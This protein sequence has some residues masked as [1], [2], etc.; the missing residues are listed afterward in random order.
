M[1]SG[2][3]WRS[4][5]RSNNCHYFQF[6][7]ARVG[8]DCSSILAQLG[9]LGGLAT[10]AGAGLGLKN[11]N[12]LQVALLKSRTVEDAMIARFHLMDLYHKKRMSQA[13]DK[14]EKVIDISSS[15]KD[16]LIRVSATDSDPQRASE[17][18]NGYVE[19]FR[20]LSATLAVTEASQRRLFFENQL[21][22]AKDNLSNAEEELKKTQQKSGLIQLDSQTRAA[23]ESAAVL[24]AQVS[25]KEVQIRALQSYATGENPEAQIAEQELAGLQSELSKI[26]AAAD[27]TAPTLR[28]GAMQQEGLDYIRK[29]RDVRYYETI[30]ELLARQLEAAKVDEARQGAMVQV[31]D[32]AEIPDHHS[33]PKRTIIVL[34]SVAL[35]MLV[36]VVWAFAS[37][38]IHRISENPAERP[39]LD[40]LRS[41]LGRSPR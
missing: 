26:G 18:A 3:Y 13:R 14:L 23:I 15:T 11:P 35:G 38:G 22:D 21:R 39:R 32:R 29:L 19:E 37:E 33:S 4:Y 31:V 41:E 24:R 1:C 16:P 34:V 17:L 12:D 27:G 28:S 8:L 6:A 10:A 7:A 9:N 20:K 30:F 36:G 2:C 25:A 40:T 5:F